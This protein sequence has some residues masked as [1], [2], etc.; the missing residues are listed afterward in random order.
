MLW[1]AGRPGGP[2]GSAGPDSVGRVAPLRQAPAAQ[3]LPAELVGELLLHLLD[4]ACLAVVA[5]R[6]GHLLVGHL[7]AVALLDAPAVCQRLLVLGRELEGALVLVY[8]PD[9]VLH[10]PAAQ[11]VEQELVQADLL[12][13]A[14]GRRRSA[15]Q[16]ADPRPPLYGVPWGVVLGKDAVSRGPWGTGSPTACLVH[17]LTLTHTAQSATTHTHSHTH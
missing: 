1:P 10:V 7:L 4:L 5:Q 16:H 6:A 8:P 12:L 15:R 13:A 17:T 11:Q 2:G 9:A 3:H 14:C